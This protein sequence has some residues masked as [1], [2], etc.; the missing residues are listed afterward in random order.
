MRQCKP[1]DPT[2]N[3]LF[4]TCIA[5]NCRAKEMVSEELQQHLTPELQYLDPDE[6]QQSPPSFECRRI[7][8]NEHLDIQR[9]PLGFIVL[10]TSMTKLSGSSLCYIGHV[11]TRHFGGERRE[12]W[13]CR[14][15]FIDLRRLPR[16][17]E[18]A[19]NLGTSMARDFKSTRSPRKK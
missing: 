13:I 17:F 4:S 8:W 2:S 11:V 19:R 5:W 14:F 9:S 16:V 12:P 1:A 10:F 18:T 3:A 7:S 6:M 15:F